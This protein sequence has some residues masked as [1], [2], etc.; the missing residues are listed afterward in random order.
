MR[1]VKMKIKP[2]FLAFLILTILSEYS[3][4]AEIL[5]LDFESVKETGSGVSCD[6]PS[7]CD[8]Y[9]EVTIDG[10]PFG[11]PHLTVEDKQHYV[12]PDDWAFR[13]DVSNSLNVIDITVRLWERDGSGRQYVM[14]QK[15]SKVLKLRYNIESKSFTGLTDE[16][17]NPVKGKSG[18]P[19]SSIG[20][21]LFVGRGAK[22]T[23]KL[24]SFTSIVCPSTRV[25]FNYPDETNT[26]GTSFNPYGPNV[27]KDKQVVIKDMIEGDYIKIADWGRNYYTIIDGV[28]CGYDANG[29]FSF[30]SD[31]R[32]KKVT[33]IDV[34]GNAIAT[35][36][37]GVF[38]F[39]MRSSQNPRAQ[40]LEGLADVDIAFFPEPGEWYEVIEFPYKNNYK[41]RSNIFK[42]YGD[43]KKCLP[44]NKQCFVDEKML[45]SER[46]GVTLQD[47]AIGNNEL[48]GDAGENDKQ[49][50]ESGNFPKWEWHGQTIFY[51]LG[52]DFNIYWLD[53]WNL[54]WLDSYFVPFAE[55][56]G[57]AGWVGKKGYYPGCKNI[58]DPVLIFCNNEYTEQ[59]TDYAPP[60]VLG[61][62]SNSRIDATDS[63][64]IVTTKEYVY[65][66]TWGYHIRWDR[67]KGEQGWIKHN[68]PSGTYDCRIRKDHTILCD[69]ERDGI[70]GNY[71]WNARQPT[72]SPEFIPDAYLALY[73][74]TFSFGSDFPPGG[75]NDGDRLSNG[76]EVN[77]YL[78]NPDNVDTDG[79][80]VKDGDEVEILGTDPLKKDSDGDGINDYHEDFDVDRL[81]NGVELY[82]YHTNPKNKDS[83]G[84]KLEDGDEVEIFNTE[85]W[86]KHTDDDLLTDYE[87]VCWDGDCSRYTPGKDLDPNHPDTDGDGLE[88]GDEVKILDTNP[89]MKDPDDDGLTDYEEVCWDGDCSEYTEGRDPGPNN[90]DTDGDGWN[91][92]ED[93]NPLR[94][95]LPVVDVNV[96]V[97]SHGKDRLRDGHPTTFWNTDGDKANSWFEVVLEVPSELTHLRLA[98]RTNRAYK[99]RAF[100]DSAFVGQY[101]TASSPTVAL[102][103]FALPA[104]TLGTVVRVET[105][106]SRWFRV[107]EVELLG[108]KATVPE[109]LAIVDTDVAVNTF[110]KKHLH[111]GDLATAWANDGDMAT[112]WFDVTLDT[113]RE[114]KQ[115]RLAPRINRAYTFNM[116]VDNSFVGQYTTESTPFVALQIFDI[117]AG[118]VGS[119][120]RVESVS[121]ARFKVHEVE[122][123]DGLVTSGFCGSE[124]LTT[125]VTVPVR[126]LRKNRLIDGNLSSDS[127]WTNW[128]HS[129]D[130]WFFE[131]SLASARE[132]RCLKLAPP[133][134]TAYL[135]DVYVDGSFVGQYTTARLA[136]VAL[137]DFTLPAGT[138][139]SVVRVESARAH[140]WFKV[141]EVELWGGT[142]V[143]DPQDPVADADGPYAV[144]DKDNSGAEDVVLDGSASGDPDG[145]TIVSWEWHKGS[146]LLGTG[147]NS[148]FPFTVVGS[149]HTVT[150]TVIDDEGATGTDTTTV[151]VNPVSTGCGYELAIT[152]VTVP[153]RELRKN[154]LIDG[155]LS[156]G[157]YWTNW[158]HRGDAWFEVSMTSA[159]EI[160]CLKLAP[161]INTAYLFD[162]YVDGSFVGQYTTA[163]RATITLQGFTLPA[164][165]MGS[166]VRVESVGPHP[167]F[168]V[169]ELEL[170]GE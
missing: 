82:I 67:S 92:G 62:D 127:Y 138:M 47:W 137:Q 22:I 139:G 143:T 148:V 70:P 20:G 130:T 7:G 85:P 131:V 154:R 153:V 119:V 165:T 147:M 158:L 19:V 25:P 99:F 151:M 168:K 30:R 83:D 115:L 56:H 3:L 144:T 104:G 31:P 157:S 37:N 89:L 124:L 38:G 111:D 103:T 141:H 12:A 91:D 134:N 11:G 140:P 87:E 51:V 71:Y 132:I 112:A 121:S 77:D 123:R 98:P 126:E 163:W 74:R 60:P 76:K 53:V 21:G 101:T 14:I 102:Q 142:G 164:G 1:K 32:M 109:Q 86:T 75:D 167:W 113:S 16:N 129:G 162:V 160:R 18:V 58:T 150:L 110:R 93:K 166:V 122:L 79:E 118:T 78:T 59:T 69:G 106:S 5:K 13:K 42:L 55:W 159:R 41:P 46:V 10:T 45:P 34:D 161:P 90:P 4:S 66:G 136:V 64:F 135:F 84:D 152:D 17:G 2:R 73:D 23:F 128:L 169:Q 57:T 108:R 96:P 9:P 156:S 50:A 72:G 107:H 116:Y 44:F 68:N 114:L 52:S 63:S 24:T 6:T 80:G 35:Y 81:S 48:I 97:R 27:V 170:H 8:Y 95:L 49:R 61:A 26:R 120:V 146:T 28:V 29:N 117:P 33:S 155:N 100:V 54:S 88:D 133:I 40:K 36:G 125:D 43:L 15:D 39:T 94:P 145:G 105:V 65:Y 149:P